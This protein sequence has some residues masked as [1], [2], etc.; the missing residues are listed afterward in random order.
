MTSARHYSDHAPLA[1]SIGYAGL[2]LGVSDYPEHLKWVSSEA[3]I[4]TVSSGRA[5]G[6]C[7]HVSPALNAIR[8]KAWQI[9]ELWIKGDEI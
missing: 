2:A 9:G 6:R 3:P 8:K 7:Y 5:H 1:S 4:K